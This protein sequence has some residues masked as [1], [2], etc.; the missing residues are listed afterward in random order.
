MSR[1]FLIASKDKRNWKINKLAGVKDRRRLE[2]TNKCCCC[3][4]S[5]L[6][7]AVD[8]EEGKKE[9]KIKFVE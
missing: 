3:K 7:S 8:V 5:I 6:N 4:K 9:K 2:A 1:R